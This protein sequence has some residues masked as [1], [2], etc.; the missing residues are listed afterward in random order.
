MAR[1]RKDYRVDAARHLYALN[2]NRIYKG[3]LPAFLYAV[4]VLDVMI[5]R[6]G[7]V[8]STSWSR[9]PEH[10]PA[11]MAEIVRTIE[12][13]S[14]LPVPARLGRT[15][16]TDVWLWHKSGKFQLDSLSEGQA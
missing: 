8:V 6:K 12:K 15:V 5:D 11:V 10:A 13:A 4:G 3:K 1:T 7:N 9:A 2:A 16:Y 14:P